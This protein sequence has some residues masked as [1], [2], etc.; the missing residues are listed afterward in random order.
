MSINL[1]NKKFEYVRAIKINNELIKIED[2]EKNTVLIEKYYHSLKILKDLFDV[3]NDFDNIIILNNDI[4]FRKESLLIEKDISEESIINEIKSN[5]ISKIISFCSEIGINKD[6][7]IK[8]LSI[9]NKN[10]SIKRYEIINEEINKSEFL[11]EKVNSISSYTGEKIRIL[12]EKDIV[13]IFENEKNDKEKGLTISESVNIKRA[14]IIRENIHTTMD[15]P[16]MSINYEKI[17]ELEDLKKYFPNFKEVIDDIIGYISL[18]LI[19]KETY[20]YMK[21]ILLAGDPGLGKTAFAKSVAKILNL[22][23]KKIPLT[24]VTAAW[25]ITG[26]D[27][28]W[29]GGKAGKIF[30]ILSQTGMANPIIFLDEID[31]S[32]NSETGG[33]PLDT[34]H[35]LL[36]KETSEDVLDEALNMYINASKINWIATAN[37]LN[38]IPES[39]LSRFQIFNILDIE[40]ENEKDFVIKNVLSNIIKD[41]PNGNCFSNEINIEILNLLREKN[42]RNINNEITRAMGKAA[43][44]NLRIKEDEKIVLLKEDFKI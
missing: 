23:F 10:Q 28:S 27:L 44:R 2:I 36:E 24:T 34:L 25:V 21:P 14:S 19:G 13:N 29:N 9:K 31:K 17:N 43:R 3:Q 20:F 37:D 7:I 30:S 35:D 38:K 32:K 8:K 16:L 5:Y 39:I 42:I 6:A 40:K 4:L 41:I 26:L 12:E 22:G 33:N 18:S 11:K 1:Y 15:Y